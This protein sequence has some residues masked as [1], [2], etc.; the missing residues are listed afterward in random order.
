MLLKP[1]AAIDSISHTRR[2]SKYWCMNSST[3]R[4]FLWVSLIDITP[5]ICLAL[6]GTAPRLKGIVLL[7][8]FPISSRTPFLLIV[9]MTF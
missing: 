8:D 5:V 9:I 7:D 2:V 1:F 6:G 3:H 4:V